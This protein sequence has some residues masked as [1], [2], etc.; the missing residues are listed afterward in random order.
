MGY[1]PRSLRLSVFEFTQILLQ[2][3][4]DKNLRF[5]LNLRTPSLLSLRLS[6]DL[7][8]HRACQIY[9]LTSTSV[10]PSLSNLYLNLDLRTPSPSTLLIRPRANMPASRTWLGRASLPRPVPV[11]TVSSAE[12]DQ[13]CFRS[14]DPVLT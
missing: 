9:A 1:R 10:T 11:S 2:V 7:C 6:L 5:N 12:Q 13:S 3:Y 8:N 14:L 4:R